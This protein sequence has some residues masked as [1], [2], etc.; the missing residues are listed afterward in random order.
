MQKLALTAAAHAV[1]VG[2][3]SGTVQGACCKE[4]AAAL[5]VAV[6]DSGGGCVGMVQR[7]H[8]TTR[9]SGRWSYIQCHPPLQT[10]LL[11]D[12][13]PVYSLV[14]NTETCSVLMVG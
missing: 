6:A 9:I 4:H 11:Y 13:H 12:H 2:L 3:R 8:G 10:D 7:L 1:E 14:I 5:T